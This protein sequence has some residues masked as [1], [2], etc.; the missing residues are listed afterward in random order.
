MDSRSP[1][2]LAAS[3]L[4]PRKRA[5]GRRAALVSAPPPN[6]PP[7]SP[8]PLPAQA[9]T[10]QMTENRRRAEELLREAYT[11]AECLQRRCGAGILERLLP[12]RYKQY[13]KGISGKTA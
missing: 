13:S 9:L 7:L 5:G 4:P 12:K 1:V 3:A 11:L 8:L 2:W 10:P 6:A